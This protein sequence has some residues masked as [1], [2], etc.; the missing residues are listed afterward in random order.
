MTAPDSFDSPD[1]RT[2]ST[3]E[4]AGQAASVAFR[5]TA[6]AETDDTSAVLAWDELPQNYRDGWEAAAS[7]ALDATVAGILRA[8]DST[9]AVIIAFRHEVGD[10]EA[11]LMIDRWREYGPEGVNIIIVEDVAAIAAAAPAPAADLRDRIE[12]ALNAS[13]DRCARCKTCDVQVDAVMAVV[14][15]A[16]PAPAALRALLEEALFLR[17]NG[18]YAPGGR[19]NWHD[20]DT[21]AER[22]LRG[23]PPAGQPQ[24]AP[25]LADAMA[26][27]ASRELAAAMRETR[28]Y[29]E[30]LAEVASHDN[31]PITQVRI[32]ARAARRALEGKP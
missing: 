14:A 31:D 28:H 5:R 18:E 6:F 8:A 32:I 22:L 12:A 9:G 15:G 27:T 24:A 3:P 17:Q 23:L 20:W 21:K 4:V 7:A 30:A 19:E 13:M 10:R 2:Y 26:E 1:G 29:R 25:E 11:E 16:A